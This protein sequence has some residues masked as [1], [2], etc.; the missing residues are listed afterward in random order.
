MLFRSS[1]AAGRAVPVPGNHPSNTTTLAQLNYDV[2]PDGRG[3]IFTRRVSGPGA[4]A[5]AQDGHG[6]VK[7]VLNWFEEL[8]RLAPAKP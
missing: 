6:S 3:F 8:K 4:G 7:V 2:T 1:L 5:D